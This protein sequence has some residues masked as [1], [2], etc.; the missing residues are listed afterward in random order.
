MAEVGGYDKELQEALLDLHQRGFASDE[1]RSSAANAVEKIAKRS[2]PVDEDLVDMLTKWLAGQEGQSGSSDK[3]E[4]PEVAEKHEDE[5][6]DD[7]RQNSILWG[8]GN[9]SFLP[10]GNYPILSAL[11]SILLKDLEGRDRLLA[12]L[13]DHLPREENPKVWQAFLIRLSNAGGSAPEIVSTF[14]RALFQRFPKLLETR[15]A[16]NFLAY[17]HRWDDLLVLDLIEPWEHSTNP[18]LRQ[19][20]GELVGLVATVHGTDRWTA[21]RSRLF[22][23]GSLEAKIGMAYAGANLWTDTRFHAAAGTLLVRLLPGADKQQMSAIFDVFRVCDALIPEPTTLAFLGSLAA[24]EVDLFGT[25]S[26]FIV[27]KLQSML[28]H[29][30]DVIGVIAMKLVRAWRADL[31][32]IQTAGAF[33]APQLTD[34]AI[35]LHRIGGSSR[36]TGVSVFEALID[37]DAEGARDTLA[38]IDGRFGTPRTGPHRRVARRAVNRQSHRAA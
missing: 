25:P 2:A 9:T 1:F 18:M 34:L 3:T 32:N 20:Q 5:R 29:A 11:T 10:G 28:P 38:E 6:P 37:L 30:A 12:I 27:E 14:L 17:A 4:T 35:T 22:D 31:G 8:H 19:A 24:P 23:R 13:N 36:E 15:E 26:D 21:V 33:A 7:V 16:V